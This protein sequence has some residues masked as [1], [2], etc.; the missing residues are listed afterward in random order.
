MAGY[1][2]TLNS[3]EAL[4]QC[5]KT[6]TYSTILNEP[7]ASKWLTNHEGTFADYLSMKAGD[8]VFFFIKR[9]IYGCGILVNVKNVDCKFLNY[10]EADV[11]RPNKKET[12]GKKH[13]L[14]YGSTNNRCF[15]VFKPCPHFFKEGIDMDEILQNK[16]CPFHAVRTLWK[17]SFIKM[18]EIE[19]ITLFNII[20]KNNEERLR[21]KEAH[22]LYS[23]KVLRAL[24]RE[25]L[26]N[27]RL[28]GKGII[29]TCINHKL[30]DHEMALEASLCEKLSNEGIQPFGKW[31]YVSH[32][33]PASPFKP[34]DYMD[35][36]DIFGYK[37]MDDNPL[38]TKVISKYLIAELKKGPAEKEVV[39]QIMKYV[40]WVSD[41]YANGDYSMIEAYVVA[42]EFSEE[43]KEIVRK[44][45]IRNF[46]KGFRPTKFCEWKNI[47]LVK[48]EVEN[49][50][51][52]YEVIPIA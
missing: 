11:P 4:E 38:A 22:Y 31:N 8:L 12:Y 42:S 18:D 46:N 50:D 52:R 14:P 29:K 13:L 17:L 37:Y 26:D 7:R 10:K 45:C 16:S 19:A 2:I 21:D 24:E 47:K 44:H 49:D 30:L 41:E 1:L 20:L 25:E 39:E 27:Y 15:C 33:V 43:I 6:G 9:K 23:D 36:M 5:I 35:K 40:D 28:T 3:E 51:L 32:Q 48:Y 34:I